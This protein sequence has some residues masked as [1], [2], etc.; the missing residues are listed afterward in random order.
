M[1]DKVNDYQGESLHWPH[2]DQQ[3]GIQSTFVQLMRMLQPSEL[4][5]GAPTFGPRS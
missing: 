1:H 3:Q 5:T 2:R 4:T